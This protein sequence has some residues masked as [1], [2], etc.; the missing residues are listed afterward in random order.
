M[1]WATVTSSGS[2]RAISSSSCRRTRSAVH[3]SSS[4][5]M[6]LCGTSTVI[7][8]LSAAN[9][10]TSSSGARRH[11]LDRAVVA[12]SGRAHRPAARRGAS[13]AS[14]QREA[15]RTLDLAEPVAVAQGEAHVGGVGGQAARS[16]RGAA[17]PRS[18][19]RRGGRMLGVRRDG[20][21]AAVGG[22]LL[23]AREQCRADTAPAQ[24]GNDVDEERGGHGVLLQREVGDD[25]AD[26]HAV[27]DGDE[28][29][30]VVELLRLERRQLGLG[31]VDEVVVAP[32]ERRRSP[33]ITATIS[34]K[35]ADPGFRTAPGCGVRRWSGGSVA[36]ASVGTSSRTRNIPA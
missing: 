11:Q 2:P 26:D 1:C 18:P 16:D 9:S 32:R 33:F 28:H 34:S 31:R 15:A 30:L 4:R 21:A 23:A 19:C 35:A 8:S 22:E 25:P 14:G 12:P 20:G 36:R 7:R 10:A 6:P 27:D 17:R 5:A 13:A 24:R 29:D 3:S